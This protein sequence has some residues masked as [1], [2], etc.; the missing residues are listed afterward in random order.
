MKE[1]EIN[2]RIKQ[3]AVL[4]QVSFE[5]I[6]NPKEH[7]EKTLTMYLEKVK[8][9]PDV[10]V[11]NEELGAAEEIEGGLWSTYAD[12][13]ILFDK[14][15]KLVWVCVNFMPAS[16]EIIAPAEFKLTD[17]DITLWLN[18]LISRIHEIAVSVRQTTTADN[19]LVKSMNALIQNAVLLAAE[20]YHKPKEIGEKIGIEEEQLK[21]FFEAL[22][23][24]GK[25]EKKGDAYYRKGVKKEGVKKRGAKKTD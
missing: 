17:K 3:G 6:G 10:T 15:E 21:P 2:K 4:A 20:K 19:L 13:E 25:L 5:I 1:E 23:N 22:V 18:D 9:E 7:V 12:V 14:L 24:Q 11:L 16:V 8:K